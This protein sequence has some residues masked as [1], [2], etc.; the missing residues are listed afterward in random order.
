MC[1]IIFNTTFVFSPKLYS[2]KLKLIKK[3]ERKRSTFK[4]LFFVQSCM[5]QA[6]WLKLQAQHQ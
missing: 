6:K 5:I 2:H 3:E 1:T 4:I